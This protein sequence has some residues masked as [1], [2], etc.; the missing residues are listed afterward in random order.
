MTAAS[1]L[2]LAVLTPVLTM[3]PGAH[4]G[5]EE[6]GTI[7]D[8]AR[9]ADAADALGYDHITCS[10]HFA[11][12]RSQAVRRGGTVLGSSQHLW[13]RR[14]PHGA[15]TP[16]HERARA[17]LPPSTRNRETLRD[18]RPG[19]WWAARSGRRRRHPQGGV[20]PARCPLRRPGGSGG[21]RAPG[22]PGVPLG[23]GAQLPRG[24][25]TTTG[26][27]W[28]TRVQPRSTSRSGSGAERCVRSAE[29]PSWPT[30]GAHSGSVRTGP[31]SGLAAPN[32]LLV[33]RCGSAPSICSTRQG[34]R[35]WWP[36]PSAHWPRPAPRSSRRGSSIIRWSTTSNSLRLWRFS[37]LA[38]APA[39]ACSTAALRVGRA[40]LRRASKNSS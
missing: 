27:W 29:Q 1:T 6:S 40:G 15:D 16:R 35:P 8:V 26:T 9:I 34:R 31:A 10:E 3:M 32:C 22:A 21:R 18:T 17:R 20:R 25:T 33:S 28:S 30:A 4:A 14:R 12:P 2:R 24:R 36:T 19:E 23:R 39:G 7:E 11:V 37:G 5:W 38:S 13:L